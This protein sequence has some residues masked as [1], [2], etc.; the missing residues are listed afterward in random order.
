MRTTKDYKKLV[1]GYSFSLSILKQL[2]PKFY[3]KFMLTKNLLSKQGTSFA[4]MVRDLKIDFI[5]EHDNKEPENPKILTVDKGFY[6][7]KYTLNY[8]PGEYVLGLLYEKES[9]IGKKQIFC[10]IIPTTLED[11]K[12]NTFMN[13]IRISKV[14]EEN[15]IQKVYNYIG[16][17]CED[18]LVVLI[19]D[20]DKPNAV[21]DGLDIS[22]NEIDSIY[23]DLTSIF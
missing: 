2:K 11:L 22:L 23:E 4:E 16:A 20:V 5:N 14:D 19:Q 3:D 13:I 7:E 17:I 10:E 9:L 21:K 1:E 18:S 12:K 8:L 15:N 6:K